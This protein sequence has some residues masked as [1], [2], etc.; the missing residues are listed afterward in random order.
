MKKR[1]SIYENRY[2]PVISNLPY[3][4]VC[5]RIQSYANYADIDIDT[6]TDTD[7]DTDKDTVI[8]TNKTK[9]GKTAPIKRRSSE[10]ILHIETKDATCHLL[11]ISL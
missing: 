10:R 7:I 2:D 3:A 9:N 6:D 8:D 5:V 1:R 4:L 11:P